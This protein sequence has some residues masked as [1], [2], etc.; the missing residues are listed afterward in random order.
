MKYLI[1]LALSFSLF[2][3]EALYQWDLNKAALKGNE[4][5]PK[6]G[7]LNL[8]A[9]QIK[10]S[11]AKPHAYINSPGAVSILNAENAFPKKSISV[12]SWVK[13]DKAAKWGGIFSLLQDNGPYKRGLILGYRFNKFCFAVSAEKRQSFYYMT[14]DQFFA[15]GFWYYVV[16]T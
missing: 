6:K 7:T 8:A 9:E 5:I 3:Q 13:V 1:I 10:F 12:A 4:F 2:S 14:S 16:G 11:D 15:P